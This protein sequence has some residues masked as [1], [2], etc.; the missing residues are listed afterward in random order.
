MFL[1][2]PYP[3]NTDLKHLLVRTFAIGF[4]VFAFLL[5]FKPFG[6]HALPKGLLRV[7]LAYGGVTS[8]AVFVIGMLG[9]WVFPRQF[10]ED[11]WTVG[12]EIFINL[13]HVIVI[14]QGNILVTMM[15]GFAA[16]NISLLLNFG[17][18]TLF[19]GFFPITFGIILKENQ[20][21]RRNESLAQSM[22]KALKPEAYTYEKQSSRMA[23]ELPSQNKN[24]NLTLN[25]DQIIYLQAQDNYV[26]VVYQEANQIKKQLL[27][28]SLKLMHEELQ[29]LPQM[30]R[31]HKSYIV[32]LDHVAEAKGNAQGYRLYFH[33]MDTYVLVSRQSVPELKKILLKQA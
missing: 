8:L 33:S 1:Q 26:E 16:F 9:K 10:H 20:L 14:A 6:L 21:R 24:E 25:P 3:L 5:F 27:R 19:V 18:I 13:L 4:F 15:F 23:I 22:S 30:M 7:A 31:C 11:R 29:N 2:K 32:N 17:L 28:A 12:R